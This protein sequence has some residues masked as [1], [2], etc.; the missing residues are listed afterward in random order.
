[1]ARLI[2]G[3]IGLVVLMPFLLPVIIVVV[4]F[5]CVIGAI[6]ESICGP[7]GPHAPRDLKKG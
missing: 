4:P 1:M 3:I 7:L 2:L 5:V 6:I